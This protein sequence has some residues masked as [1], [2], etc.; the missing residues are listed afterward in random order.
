[1]YKQKKEVIKHNDYMEINLR[2]PESLEL[3]N[4]GK[5]ASSEERRDIENLIREYMDIFVWS[6]AD[7]KAYNGE[8]IKRTI[9]LKED[10]KSFM[11]KLR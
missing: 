2:S 9:H 3:I 11:Q 4:I 5:G 6:Y 10:A 7:F 8:I 1:M